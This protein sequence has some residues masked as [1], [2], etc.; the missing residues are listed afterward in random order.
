MDDADCRD[1]MNAIADSIQVS[2]TCSYLRLYE[3]QENGS[4]QQILLD[5]SKI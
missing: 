1:V 5:I 4:Y 2:G 3:R